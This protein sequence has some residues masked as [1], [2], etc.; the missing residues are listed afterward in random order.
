MVGDVGTIAR[1]LE[2][3]RALNPDVVIMDIRLAD[4]SG[5]DATR[6]LRAASANVGIVV[7]SMYSEDDQMLAAV[8]AGASAFVP[9]SAP[10]AEVIS[11]ARHAAAAPATF[12]GPDLAGALRRSRVHEHTKQRLTRRE[13]EL[14]EQL[15][16]G[17]TA[18]AIARNLYISESTVK[19]HISRIYEK[20]GAGNRA[21]ALMIALRTGLLRDEGPTP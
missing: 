6:T 8:D 13:T 4:G 3:Y 11:A 19:S 16:E 15:K 5:L 17:L 12:S 20:L 7:V 1:G 9:K 2:L 10:V 21:Q 14:L 18:A